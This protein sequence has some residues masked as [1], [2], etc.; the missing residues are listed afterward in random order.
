MLAIPVKSEGD[1]KNYRLIRLSN[2]LK[3]LLISK[4][5]DEGLTKSEEIA[6]ACLA[7]KVGSFDDPRNA[8]GL[9]HFLEHIL[10]MGSEKYPKENSF[11]DFLVANGGNDNASTTGDCTKF[12]FNV[13]DKA[14]PTAL[15]IFAN[16][17]ISPLL[18]KN[19][20]QREREA[21]D[22]EYQQASSENQIL[23]E[24]IYKSLMADSHP[25]SQFE[26]GNL[27]TL[28]ENISD[29]DLHEELL[30]L[31]SKYVANKMSLAV[32]SKRSLDELQ[33]LVVSIFSPLKASSSEIDEKI[34]LSVDEI[35][36]PEFFD[37]IYFVKPKNAKKALHLC[38]A[39]P[40]VQK[41]YKTS[42]L[43]YVANIFTNEREGGISNY[44]REQKW[45]TSLQCYTHIRGFGG[46]SHYC[47]PRLTIGL[48]D[49]GFE[50]LNE[51]LSSIFSYL[52]MIKESPVEE[53]RRVFNDIKAE[54]ETVFRFQREQPASTNVKNA[55]NSMMMFEDSDILLS[56]PIYKEFNENVITDVINSMNQRK[57]NIL[58]LD[59]DRESYDM[60]EEYF[61]TEYDQQDYPDE[62]KKLWG[63]RKLN[64]IFYLEKPN[65]FK[66]TNFEIFENDEES[67][68]S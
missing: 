64:P 54:Q 53:H 56:T 15:D 61:G 6:A 37:K 3:A 66:A 60:K 33:T 20:M 1:K 17:F 36:K 21:V 63:E 10:F 40:S 26:V 18:L 47:M 16:Q 49:L 50:H 2:G 30:K 45:M 67:T 25:A 14:F 22:S 19:S 42:P 57:F 13:A 62:Y 55:A 41:H 46:N 9:A 52:L 4:K 43:A 7:V 58:I 32:Q 59:N 44:L 68:V 28:K 29:D 39:L 12:F 5:D 24:Y 31:F 34:E 23:I 8:M 38:W 65:P 27:R 51:V 11:N 35:F 48:T